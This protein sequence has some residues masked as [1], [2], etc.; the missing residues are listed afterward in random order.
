MNTP[1][2]VNSP[3][4]KV[5]SDPPETIG[6]VHLVWVPLGPKPVQRFLASYLQHPAGIEH[7]LLVVYNGFSSEAELKPLEDLFQAVPHLPV[8]LRRRNQDL[9]SYY[10]VARSFRYTYFCFLN[11]YSELLASNWLAYLARCCRQEGVGLVG[12][13]GSWESPLSWMDR[14]S[15]AASR[16]MASR[17]RHWLRIK[18]YRRYFPPFPNAHLRT[19]AF[20]LARET[21]LKIRPGRLKNKRDAYRFEN[22]KQSLTRQVQA[23]DLQPLIVGRDGRAYE[24]QEWP[25]SRTFR[26]A[27]QG[28]LLIADNRTQEYL[29]ATPEVRASLS[30][31]AWGDL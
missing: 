5:G 10:E 4:R 21:M 3:A 20:M 12:A 2:V 8:R 6:V 9:A 30:Q 26:Q 24:S 13:T 23:M 14:M 25:C 15:L 19:N 7:D 29:V 31:A 28:N 1:E 11:S 22:G 27:D 16:N 18:L 17:L